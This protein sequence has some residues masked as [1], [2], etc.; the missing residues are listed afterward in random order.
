MKTK[1]I[2]ALEPGTEKT[3]LDVAVPDL[4]GCF[5]AG[6]SSLDAYLEACEE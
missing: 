2:V 5:S 6:G 3:A 4:P 1:Y